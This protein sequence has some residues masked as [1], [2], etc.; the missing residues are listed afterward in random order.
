M[1]ALFLHRDLLF[2]GGIPKS[3]YYF[4]Q[5]RDPQRIS[6]WVGSLQDPDAHMVAEL[7][8]QNVPIVSFGDI[9]YLLPAARLRSFIRS[10]EIEI[11]LCTS[12]KSY[13]VAKL[14]SLGLPCKVVFWIAAIPLVISG[15]LRRTLFEWLAQS[16]P[17]IFVS[18]AV[19]REF[20]FPAHDG[21]MFVIHYGVDD[22][23][24]SPEFE[25]Y[26][27]SMRR[28]FDIAGDKL[29]LGYT[30]EFVGWKDHM[31]LLRA[32]Q[33]MS[34]DEN[35]HILL[36][37]GVGH[38]L[39]KYK[40]WVADEGLSDAVSFLGARQDARRLLGLMDVYVHPSRGEGFG[41]AVAE[42]ML[43]ELP[44]VVSDEGALPELVRHNQ[45]GLIFQ[46]GNADDLSEM[47]QRLLEDNA[48]RM[49]LGRRARADALERFT[50][51]RFAQ[52]LTAAL[53]DVLDAS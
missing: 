12:F 26:P 21:P 32:M 19:K 23:L 20:M 44:V 39:E 3:F 51:A 1:R 5:H 50:P 35:N 38:L 31:T 17:L 45:T 40:K 6:L 53:E 24:R 43:A 2:H 10:H 25:P 4:A 46:A 9:G 30:A 16:D 27:V 34:G 42:A 8:A 11:L 37:I 7:R 49:Q 18:D 29:V 41:L 28:K 33:M 48:L 13:L 52:E 15:R 47:I 14:A 36:L 22:P